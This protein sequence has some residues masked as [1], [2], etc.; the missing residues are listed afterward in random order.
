MPKTFD[1][2]K[3]I[4]KGRTDVF[5]NERNKRKMSEA[6]SM[7]DRCELKTEC[8]EWAIHNHVLYGIWGGMDRK[9]IANQREVRQIVLP[10]HY[11]RMQ[12][13]IGVGRRK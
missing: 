11:A 9:E 12:G 1:I 7:C 13:Y 8:G 5:F 6:R 2:D 3:A 10:P 4:C